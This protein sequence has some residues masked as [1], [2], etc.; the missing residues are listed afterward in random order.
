MESPLL[1]PNGAP[2]T[3][4]L[5]TF[6]SGYI[7]IVRRRVR[8][9]RA[10]PVGEGEVQVVEHLFAIALVE[11]LEGVLRG[12]VRRPLQR[13]VGGGTLAVA[14][15]IAGE[16]RVAREQ[17]GEVRGSGSGVEVQRGDPAAGAAVPRSRPAIVE[18]RGGVAVE[19]ALQRCESPRGPARTGGGHERHQ[20][21]G[22][23][24]LVAPAGLAVAHVE[25][26]AE[27]AVATVPGVRGQKAHV[28][29]RAIRRAAPAAWRAPLNDISKPGRSKGRRVRT[30]IWPARPVSS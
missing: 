24:A 21:A 18:D 14:F 29:D 5:M 15:E 17:I 9:Q 8:T 27:A 6:V 26:C 2:T 23:D 12:V 19:D 1:K 11:G 7:V 3:R 10:P 20:R 13:D 22:R 30:S 4:V 25:Q 28:R 16:Q